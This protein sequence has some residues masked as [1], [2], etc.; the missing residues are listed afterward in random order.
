MEINTKIISMPPER[1]DSC[2]LVSGEVF[3]SD[4]SLFGTE[5]TLYNNENMVQKY[6][7]CMNGYFYFRLDYE[8]KYTI[9]LKKDGYDPKT[10]EFHTDLH[11]GHS[12]R[13]RYY[14]FG[15]SLRPATERSL[16]EMLVN[17]PVA[18]IKYRS[19]TDTFEH[20]K[21]Y[22]MKAHNGLPEQEVA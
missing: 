21:E 10:I 14:D 16:E 12:E 7:C 8:K 15:V 13:K 11:G 4:G 2:L 19:E 5:I 1:S 9:T 20:D 3:T 6:I 18:I 17:T 22:H